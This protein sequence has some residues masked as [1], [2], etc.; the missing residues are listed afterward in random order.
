MLI[1]LIVK[2]VVR[3]GFTGKVM[4]EQNL[5]EGK[6]VGHRRGWMDDSEWREK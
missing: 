3:I 5:E 1:C 2:S 6:G 4:F